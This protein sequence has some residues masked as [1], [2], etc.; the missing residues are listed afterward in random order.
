MSGEHPSHKLDSYKDTDRR[1]IVFCKVCSRE[2]ENLSS[3]CP[4][5]FVPL[6][7]DKFFNEPV[8]KTTERNYG[9]D[10]E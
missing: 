4:G 9:S 7:Q 6:S 10:I 8:D 3:P 5:K 1:W 2:E